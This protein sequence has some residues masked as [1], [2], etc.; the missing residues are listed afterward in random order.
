MN[1]LQSMKRVSMAIPK[2]ESPQATAIVLV[3]EQA[4]LVGSSISMMKLDD[5]VET[6]EGEW[7][8]L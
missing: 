3:T 6:E 7:A 8:I 1:L 2:Y 5:M 4:L